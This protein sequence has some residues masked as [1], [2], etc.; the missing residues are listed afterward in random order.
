MIYT[1][2]I[3]DYTDAILWFLISVIKINNKTNNESY[4]V[5]THQVYTVCCRLLAMLKPFIVC[6]H[7]PRRS[8]GKLCKYLYEAPS[9]YAVPYSDVPVLIYRLPGWYLATR[10]IQGGTAVANESPHESISHEFSRS[11]LS[12][13]YR[14][15]QRRECLVFELQGLEELATLYVVIVPCNCIII[16][17]IIITDAQIVTEIWTT[18]PGA[19]PG[20]WKGEADSSPSFPFPP[21][22]SFP[23]P[24]SLSVPS[25]PSLPFPFH[26]SPFSLPFLSCPFSPLLSP[27]FPFPCPSSF[28]S[29]RSR[30][31]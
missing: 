25:L 6:I 2:P 17:I 23:S 29:L 12:N 20:I 14:N 4:C 27:F 30:A 18:K 19:D 10:I 7:R 31:L 26:H 13:Q 24:P 28:P 16:I 15:T 9:S 22:H 1:S 5:L 11:R 21:L 8:C 3:F